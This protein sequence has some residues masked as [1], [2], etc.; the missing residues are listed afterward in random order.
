M[1]LKY[2]RSH[3][4]KFSC[5]TFF[6]GE[7]AWL[8]SVLRDKLRSTNL[9]K[10]NTHGIASY[11]FRRSLRGIIMQTDSFQKFSDLTLK[12]TFIIFFGKELK[13]NL[14]ECQHQRRVTLLVKRRN[15]Q[16]TILKTKLPLSLQN[17]IFQ[18]IFGKRS[19]SPLVTFH[20][21]VSTFLRTVI[22]NSLTAK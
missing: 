22:R 2:R 18:V 13:T 12:A 10:I 5:I 1:S 11:Y 20:F 17:K 21:F 3:F 4:N 7:A 6:S 14:I 15:R 9:I 16:R 19:F 8:R